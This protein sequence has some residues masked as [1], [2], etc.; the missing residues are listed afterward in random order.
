[1]CCTKGSGPLLLFTNDFLLDTNDLLHEPD[2]LQR[3]HLG[4]A[5]QLFLTGVGLDGLRLRRMQAL[6]PA[7]GADLELE[8][9]G[10]IED[11]LA[12]LLLLGTGVLLLLDGDLAA[13]VVAVGVVV[14]LGLQLELAAGRALLELVVIGRTQRYLFLSDAS[15]P[16]IFR[17]T[18]ADKFAC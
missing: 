9:F 17:L 4:Q 10:E 18:L 14:L 7:E 15:R 11:A 6:H 12:P 2:S 1:M 13:E 16:L 5:S 3:V 8:G